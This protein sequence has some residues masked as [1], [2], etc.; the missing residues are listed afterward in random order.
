V[1][2]RGRGEVVAQ[3]AE[4]GLGDGA[5]EFLQGLYAVDQDIRRSDIILITVQ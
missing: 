4:V 2:R 1:R 5:V 3:A